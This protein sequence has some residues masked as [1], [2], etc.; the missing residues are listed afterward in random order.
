MLR[1]STWTKAT[2]P[3]TPAV[4][5]M[6]VWAEVQPASAACESA[7]T[8]A[9]E[10]GGAQERAG[11]VEPAPLR[12]AGVRGDHPAG[13]DGKGDADRE[14]DE[15]DRLPAE[16]LG[17]DSAEQHADS[18]AGATDGAP[19]SQRVGARRAL[20]EGA[21]QDRQGRGRQQ[22]G[23]E[24]LAGA[25]GEQ[26]RG[27]ARERGGQRG[28]DEHAET[29]QEHA[30]AAQEV[31]GASAEEQQASEDE[32][33]ARDGPADI[34][35]GDAEA[36]GD[37]RHGDVDGRDVEDDHQL[38]DAEQEEQLLEPSHPPTGVSGVVSGVV[39]GRRAM[40]VIGAMGGVFVHVLTLS[41]GG[42][43][44]IGAAP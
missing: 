21:H 35:A 2:R 22:R 27:T 16:Q 8:M 6:T 17:Q 28:G 11:Q 5:R 12:R 38:R 39:L 29:G 41:V 44:D 13:G 20:R 7:K 32:R 4:S 19:G 18:R 37:V 31:S 40:R 3:A 24:P 26:R 43:G 42:F 30:P 34:A 1:R 9:P 14:V 25:S 23:A 36:L 33:V 15:E 10:A